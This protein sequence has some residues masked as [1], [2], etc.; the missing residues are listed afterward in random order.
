MHQCT[1]A[2]VSGLLI[3]SMVV[4]FEIEAR[5]HIDP[6]QGVKSDKEQRDPQTVPLRT[7]FGKAS[8]VVAAAVV[9]AAVY[10]QSR[11]RLN[12]LPE[13]LGKRQ[14]LELTLHVVYSLVPIEGQLSE[15]LLVRLASP[16]LPVPSFL[17]K[18]TRAKQIFFLKRDFQFKESIY[19]YP[20]DPHLFFADMS[21][22]AELEQW[23]K[24]RTMKTP[25]HRPNAKAYY[26]VPGAVPH[27][28]QGARSQGSNPWQTQVMALGVSH[29]ARIFLWI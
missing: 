4:P 9:D 20:A 26:H 22:I 19:Y 11:Q 6:T 23:A 1:T 13:K 27:I 18:L 24:Q 29:S 15:K 10:K 12:D 7:S 3:M 21:H 17:F 14:Y 25:I 8:H 5:W 2:L 16:G 28:L